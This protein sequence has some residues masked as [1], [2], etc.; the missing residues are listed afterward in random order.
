MEETGPAGGLEALFGIED[1]IEDKM[2]IEKVA[3]SR[4]GVHGLMGYLDD[5]FLRSSFKIDGETVRCSLAFGKL[6][7]GR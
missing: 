4:I 7:H 1:E 6:R 5:F 3:E 2:E